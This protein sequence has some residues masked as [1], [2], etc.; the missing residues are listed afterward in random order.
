[1]R[2]DAITGLVVAAIAVVIGA[3]V[4]TNKIADQ[5]RAI[6]K[7]EA[8]TGGSWF[9][10]REALASRPCGQCHEIPGIRGARGKVGPSLASWSGRVYVDGRLQNTPQNLIG[11]IR[12]PHAIDPQN[13]MP[14]I[15]IGDRE[16]RDMAAYLYTLN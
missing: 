13:A 14:T 12:D 15:G 10:G 8:M 6:E 16:A 1:M 11:W 7:A 4:I 3:G 9:A 5:R 2:K